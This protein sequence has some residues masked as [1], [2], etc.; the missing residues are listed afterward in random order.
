MHRIFVATLLS[1]FALTAAAATTPNPAHDALAVDSARP[2]STG[3]TGPQIYY[4]TR[5]DIPADEI[6]ASMPAK[7]GLKVSLDATGSPTA[8]QVTQPLTNAIDA[9]VVDAV[10]QFR[11]RP[12]VLDNQTIPVDM[13]LTVQLQ[14]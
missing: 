12:A 1:S 7:V 13:N 6:P 2:V 9:R 3:V 11:W 14:Q 4:S 5:I 8:V 10:R